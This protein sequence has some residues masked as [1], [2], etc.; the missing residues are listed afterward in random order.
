M[1]LKWVK[2]LLL[3]TLASLTIS[4]ML[5]RLKVTSAGFGLAVNFGLMFWFTTRESLLKP[6]LN[7]TYFDA[8]PFENKGT[9][10]RRLG[11]EWYRAILLKS[12]WEKIRQK[13][14]PLKKGLTA[15]E[16]YERAT[17]VA[18]VGHLVVGSVVLLL[19]GY[20]LLAYSLQDARWL[21]LSNLL[22]NAYPI[23][24]QRYTRPRLR[25]MLVKFRSLE[26]NGI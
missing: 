10:Y 20:V 13:Q 11:V 9:F 1:L 6:T 24:L 19:I 5:L 22:L 17:R 4:F 26:T 25:R 7:A 2:I 23:L 21:I 3:L 8:Y 14:T 12:G 18:E 16:A 15:F